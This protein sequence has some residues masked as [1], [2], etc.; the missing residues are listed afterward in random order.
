MFYILAAI[1][2]FTGCKPAKFAVSEDL[3]SANDAYE[4]KGKDGIMI[5]QKL[6]FGEFK[7]T[8]VKR[9]WTRGNSGLTGFGLGTPYQNNWVNIISTEYINKKQ[10]VNFGL[11]DGSLVSDVY[12]VSRF[13]SQD[14]QIGA[15]ENSLVNI[16]LDLSGC[17]Y[18]SGSTYYVQ[19]YTKAGE[20]PWEL[21]LDNEEVQFH[22]RTY[23]GIIARSKEEFYTIHP[24]TRIEINGK[25]G[26]TL[27]GSVGFE[28][29]D[30]NGATA[31]AVSMMNRGTVIM[32][33]RSAEER[34]LLAN[35][36]AALLLQ[37]HIGE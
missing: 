23:S 19:L 22:S 26:N 25:V 13:N 31:A 12:C 6:S 7:T 11:T 34:F 37:Q 16:G 33:K 21:L 14:L 9:S 5:K 24:A 28:I 17:G 15:R 2:A 4:V 8:K 3:R 30:R 1:T 32:G 20:R 36:C 27:A 29:R 35:I 10:T 18:Q